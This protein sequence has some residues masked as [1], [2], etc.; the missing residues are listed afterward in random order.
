MLVLLG[1]SSVLA[2][3]AEW[4]V[5][6]KHVPTD[7]KV[8][9]WIKN[10]GDDDIIVSEIIVTG[11]DDTEYTKTEGV[12]LQ[13]GDTLSEDFGTGESDWTPNAD[14]SQSGRYHVE[15]VVGTGNV[16]SYFNVSASFAVP[17]FSLPVALVM[18]IGFALLLGVG[19]KMNKKRM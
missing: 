1:V 11:P 9:I 13:P 8:T 6:P 2:F 3:S 17:E 15:I 16:G 4:D 18:A 12:T 10:T 14:T 7:G 19:N 5:T